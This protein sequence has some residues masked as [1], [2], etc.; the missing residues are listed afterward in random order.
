PRATSPVH[1]PRP[2][3]VARAVVL[4]WPPP[5]EERLRLP[6]AELLLRI[7]A[8]GVA[9]VMPDH[10]GR[11][12]P[13]RPATF[14]QP[15]AD[16]HVVAGSPELRIESADRFEARPAERHVAPGDVLGLPVGQEYVDR[17]PGC[18]GHAVGD[19]P[20]T[21]RRQVGSAHA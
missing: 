9:P 8:Q 3:E 20:V 21:W 13:D 17:T 4:L 19:R 16:V 15:P 10:R 5:P 18:V 11:V 7:R 12:E 2:S 14:A 1:P 6:V